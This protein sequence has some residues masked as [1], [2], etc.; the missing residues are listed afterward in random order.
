MS[1]VSRTVLREQIKEILLERILRGEL[2][3]GERLVETRLARELGTSQAPVREALRDLQ[4][5]RL[6]ESEPFRGAR[7]RA[8]DDS[9]LLPVF[10]VRAALEEL[11]AREAARKVDGEV[12]PLDRELEAMR[13]AA[14]RGDWR[15]QISHDI[16]F[17]R[18]TVELAGNEP[19]LQSWLGLGVEV[20]TA[21]AVYWTF[22]DQ[23][24]LAEFHV[25]IVDAI[26]A[27]DSAKAGSEA[28]K[29]V[30]RTERVVRRRTRAA[31]RK[32]PT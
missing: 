30:R 19:L 23:S 31:E 28:R 12:G 25:P 3:P 14:A 5:L 4:L 11:A 18:V 21:F 10:P 27:G 6:V 2:E 20:S 13:D 8:V 7:V 16:A 26:R 15:T 17:H 24:D 22:W 29:H 1:T 32:R 9:Q